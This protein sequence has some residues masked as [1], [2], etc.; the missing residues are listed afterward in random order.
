MISA[1]LAALSFSPPASHV[2]CPASS[3][4]ASSV[5][6]SLEQ[7]MQRRAVLAA[8]LGLGASG[9]APAWAGYVTSLG[10]VTTKPADAERD[11][12]LFATKEVQAGVKN[13]QQYRETAKALRATFDKDN[14]MQLIP[15]IRKDF[16]FSALRDD[17]NVVATIFDDQ[18]QLTTDRASR[19]ILYDLTELENAARF[20]KGETERTSKKIENVN[21]WFGKLDADLATLLAYFA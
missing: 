21:K 11:D 8:A 18:T 14:N 15:V 13:L 4:R 10:I 2:A 7:P 17:L 5:V 12:D 19:A 3:V 16:D 9:A 20:K 6:C 1:S